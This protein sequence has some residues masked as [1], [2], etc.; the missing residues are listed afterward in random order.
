MDKLWILAA[1][2][3]RG[4]IFKADSLSGKLE[5]HLDL[6][7]TQARLSESELARHSRG[8]FSNNMGAERHGLNQQGSI[9]EHHARVFAKQVAEEL[10]NSEGQHQFKNLVL[11]ASPRFLGLLRQELCKNVNERVCFEL[12]K[13]LTTLSPSE[14]R[15][16]LPR[17]LPLA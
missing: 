13:D 10:A 5:E 2:A 6:V 1:D 8:T 14:L 4:R 11:V 7:H 16:H 12:N 17:N 9:K 3:N 15:K